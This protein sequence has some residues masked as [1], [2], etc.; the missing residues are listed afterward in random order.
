MNLASWILVGIGFIG[1]IFNIRKNK[2]CFIIWSVTNTG[3]IITSYFQSN[4]SLAFYFFACLIS[5][6]WGLVQ[7]IKDER[8]FKT[9]VES[10]YYTND[11]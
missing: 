10:G 6:I 2:W 8:R 5:S 4:Y 1:V 11:L 9:S 7:W 3:L